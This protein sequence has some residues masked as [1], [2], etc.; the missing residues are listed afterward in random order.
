MANPTQELPDEHIILHPEE[1]PQLALE[2]DLTAQEPTHVNWQLLMWQP[3]L[4]S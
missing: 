3:V 2:P 1:G 4:D